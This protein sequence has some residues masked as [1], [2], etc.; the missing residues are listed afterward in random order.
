[1]ND[2]NSPL[3]SIVTP[4]LNRVDYIEEAIQ[5]VL[6]QDYERI[7]HI[8]VDGGSTDG[9][10]DVLNK[11]NHLN[12][13]CE[14]DENLY[15]A[16]NKGIQAAKGDIIGHLNTDDFYAENI[17]AEVAGYF[18]QDSE[19]DTVCGGAMMFKELEDG[20]WLK[21]AEYVTPQDKQPSLFNAML[22]V[23]ITNARFF[24]KRIY[25]TAGLYD[26]R[27]PI[28]ADREWMLRAALVCKKFI[29]ME[30]MVYYYRVHPGSLSLHLAGNRMQRLQEK[31]EIAE[32]HLDN[33]NL[34][35]DAR[36][37]CK[38]WHNR[39]TFE[40]VVRNCAGMKVGMG[41][42][43]ALKGWRYDILWPILFSGH[44]LMRAVCFPFRRLMAKPKEDNVERP[45]TIY[46]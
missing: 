24:H 11:Y 39:E 18:A 22:G 10:L 41:L 12:V 7:E 2:N 33:E 14:P 5:S 45:D 1:M 17:M 21:D 37:L 31:I 25:D 32:M 15:D 40:S 28:A 34:P 36:T 8:V 29:I 42:R 4:C 35:P 38:A 30:R 9:T 23:P 19:L 43:Y 44:I 16:L 3:I 46:K 13:I 20:Q 6:K 27:F 26:I